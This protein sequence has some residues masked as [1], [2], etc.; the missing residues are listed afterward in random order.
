MNKYLYHR[1]N[2]YTIIKEQANNYN[3][4]RF[5]KISVEKHLTP[6]NFKI[7]SSNNYYMFGGYNKKGIVKNN[8]LFNKS[9]RDYIIMDTFNVI[10]NILIILNNNNILYSSFCNNNDFNNYKYYYKMN[11]TT[12]NI[13]SIKARQAERRAA[14]MVFNGVENSEDIDAIYNNAIS[15]NLQDY[16]EMLSDIETQPNKEDIYAF[17]RD[18]GDNEALREWTY[19]PSS[20]SDSDSDSYSDFGGFEIQ[21]SEENNPTL[22]TTQQEEIL[23]LKPLLKRDGMRPKWYFTKDEYNIGIM[24]T[25]ICNNNHQ[26]Y[27]LG[28]EQLFNKSRAKAILNKIIS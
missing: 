28:L 18:N 9:Q 14:A 11:H 10:D 5:N 4:E 21:N 15:N 3:L 20:G 2:L 6:I 12:D 13:R 26:S 22:N 19:E 17:L 8:I 16:T 25:K 23:L 7:E 24:I 27:I 1:N